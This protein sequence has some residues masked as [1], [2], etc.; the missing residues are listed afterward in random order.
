MLSDLLQQCVDPP[1]AHLE[2]TERVP[3]WPLELFETSKFEPGALDSGE[4]TVSSSMWMTKHL[5]MAFERA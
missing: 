2:I 1:Q 5:N 4:L 3:P